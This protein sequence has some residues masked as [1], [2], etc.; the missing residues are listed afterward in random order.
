MTMDILRLPKTN[1]ILSGGVLRRLGKD[2]SVLAAFPVEEITDV[3]C[4]QTKTYGAPAAVIV[5]FSAMAIVAKIYI[6]SP[7]WA[8]ATAIMCAGVSALGFAMIEETR[9]VVETSSGTVSYLVED[10]ND[11]AEG[12]AVSLKHLIKTPAS[13]PQNTTSD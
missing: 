7:G 6:P 5:F 8:W 11:E 3:R 13:S 12:F 1:L 4:E 10:D 2:Q 9:I